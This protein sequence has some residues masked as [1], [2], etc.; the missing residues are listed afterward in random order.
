[1]LIIYLNVFHVVSTIHVKPGF[2]V[3]GGNFP[4]ADRAAVFSTDI[5]INNNYLLLVTIKLL[6]LQTNSVIR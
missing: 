3:G 5:P 1:M 6:Q 2:E 4:S